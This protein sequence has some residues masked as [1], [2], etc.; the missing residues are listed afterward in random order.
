MFFSFHFKLVW[1]FY[2]SQFEILY[3]KKIA[4]DTAFVAKYNVARDL[5]TD[6]AVAKKARYFKKKKFK[7]VANSKFRR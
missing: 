3:Y 6:S 4:W 7:S 1:W 2:S 5:A